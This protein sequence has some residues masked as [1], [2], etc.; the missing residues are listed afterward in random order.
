VKTIEV[1]APGA[2]Y[3][4]VIGA[5]LLENCGDWLRPFARDGRLAVVSDEL[6]WAAQGER[7]KRG[8]AA[9]GLAAEL[10]VLP[11]GEGAKSWRGLEGLIDRLA[12]AGLERG[13]ALLAFGGGVIGDLAGFA[14]SI[15]MR[16]CRLIHV[17]TTLL[18]QVDSSIGGKSGINI[19]AGKNLVG[20]FHQPALVLIDPACLDTLPARHVR[21]GYAEIVKYGLIDE[22]AF[23]AWCEA[24]GPSL[25]AG[26]AAAREYAIAASVAAKAATVAADP[27]DTQGRRALLNLGHTFG[28]ALEAATGFS[29]RLLH[30]EAVAIGMTLAFRFS[31]ARGLCAAEDAD[32]VARALAQAGLPTSLDPALETGAAL[33]ERMRRDKKAQDGR[34]TLVLAHGIG[35][36]YLERGV[37]VAEVA[38]FLDAA[39]GE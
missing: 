5:G 17:P 32:R 31:T 13:D 22:P 21:A 2:P 20:S 9:H 10:I 38:G 16:G 35:K 15:Y 37:A 1:A 33:A 12:Q 28:H 24:H 39:R 8:L 29:D 14:A 18:A 27:R 4:A 6:A 34:L 25:I 26:D 19:A 36:A 11:P 7:L 3:R 30:G 23:F